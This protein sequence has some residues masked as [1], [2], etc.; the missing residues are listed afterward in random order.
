[1]CICEEIVENICMFS[2]VNEVVKLK[3]RLK[4][5]MFYV[6]KGGKTIGLIEYN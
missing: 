4:L 6:K 3:N 5:Y 2:Y 1:M